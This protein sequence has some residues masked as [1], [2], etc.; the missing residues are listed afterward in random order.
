MWQEELDIY[1]W[2]NF[3]TAGTRKILSQVTQKLESVC[4]RST[5]T[6]QT[7]PKALQTLRSESQAYL[8][9]KQLQLFSCWAHSNFL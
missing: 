9:S 6:E 5:T 2:Q 4:H 1:N 3:G 8:S 7:N